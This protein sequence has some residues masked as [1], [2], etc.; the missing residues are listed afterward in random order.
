MGIHLADC[1]GMT[2]EGL[3]VLGNGCPQLAL[4]DLR[5][6]AWL[7]DAGLAAI[8]LGCI[9]LHTLDVEGCERVT[10]HGLQMISESCLELDEI[11]V[12]E[13]SHKVTEWGIRPLIEVSRRLRLL[14]MI[15]I[16]MDTCLA[17]AACRCRQLQEVDISDCPAVT[18]LGF[19]LL[20][21]CRFLQVLRAPN[22]VAVTDAG[23]Q[24][25]ALGC[26]FL[27][28]RYI[29]LHCGDGHKCKQL[30]R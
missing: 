17:A 19:E 30:G 12:S 8:A 14:K 26:H 16:G 7:T 2:D 18:D 27:G 4:L 28:C 29:G 23:V 6:N 11:S 13:M 10:D 24:A 9:H 22:C 25:L 20:S 3:E 5:H 15:R 1:A 21:D